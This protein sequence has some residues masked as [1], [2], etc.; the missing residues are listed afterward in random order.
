[1][2]CHGRSTL[3]EFMGDRV[4]YRG[5]TS[6]DR[7]LPGLDEIRRQ[8]GLAEG[9]VPRKNELDYAR[10]ILHLLQVCRMQD[11]PGERI[12]NLIFIGD[13]RLLDGTAFANLCQVSRLPGLAFIASENNQPASTD[14]VAGESGDPLFLSNRWSALVDFDQ[15]CAQRGQPVQERTAALIDIDKTAI[16]ARGRNGNAIDQARMEAV[17]ETVAGLL[18]ADFNQQA[19]RSMYEPLNQPEFHPFTADN[20]DY[21]AYICLILGSGLYSYEGL[22]ESVRGGQLISFS[23]FI[24]E[25]DTRKQELTGR[26]FEIHREIYA[27]VKAGD[28]TPFKE[29]RRN[30]YR[31][32]LGRFGCLEDS[33][34]VE[35]MLA[36]EIL[37]TQEV[38]AMALAWQERGVL[39]FGL[40]DKPDE[41]SLPTPELAAQGYLPLH[42]AETHAIGS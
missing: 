2:K 14:L 37:I 16:G 33:A 3:S 42:R 13:T 27:N 1:M 31:L 40:S 24:T 39:L 11:R 8:I 6:P 20:Q 7:S 5:L 15:F 9:V 32:T 26:L 25:V 21:L 29:F 36:E 17:K 28:P 4:V 22:V 41:A 18:G 35:K 10:V 23:Q 12:E 19:F 38:R 30:E 34:P